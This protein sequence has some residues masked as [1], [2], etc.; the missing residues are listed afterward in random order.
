MSKKISP[1][2]IIS[3]D[4][5][6]DTK[7]D[8]YGEFCEFLEDDTHRKKN[9]IATHIESMGDNYLNEIDKKKNIEKVKKSKYVK[10]ILKKTDRFPSDELYSYSLPDI[11]DIYNETKLNKNST[12][13]K[14]FNFLFNV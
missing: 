6:D 2:K 10:Y 4:F 13:K 5:D 14:I 1:N 12:L 3:I 9:S 8:G 7:L 11:I